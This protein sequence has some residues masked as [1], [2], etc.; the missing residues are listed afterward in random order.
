MRKAL[1]FCVEVCAILYFNM[2]IL[3]SNPKILSI[4]NKSEVAMIGDEDNRPDFI[5]GIDFGQ[6]YTGKAGFLE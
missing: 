3:T 1:N 2:H 5:I 6:T 4:S